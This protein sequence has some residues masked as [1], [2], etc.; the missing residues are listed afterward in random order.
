RAGRTRPDMESSSHGHG[1]ASPS[2]FVQ[3]APAARASGRPQREP[4]SPASPV[5]PRATGNVPPGPMAV[6]FNIRSVRPAPPDGDVRPRA[7][8]RGDSH[9]GTTLVSL[10]K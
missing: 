9:L 2:D 4:A 10:W 3:S 1:H 8:E 5:S 6:V 7:I